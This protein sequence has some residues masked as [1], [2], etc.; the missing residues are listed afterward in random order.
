MDCVIPR[1]PLADGHPAVAG[2]AGR[3]VQ[4]QTA[5]QTDKEEPQVYANPQP[6]VQADGAGKV[7]DIKTPNLSSSST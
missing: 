2:G 7:L 6:P 1:E 5:V 4:A 3:V